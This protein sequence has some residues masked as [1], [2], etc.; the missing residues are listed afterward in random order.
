MN[1]NR[2]FSSPNHSQR[3]GN[4]E[5]V[6]IHFTEINFEDTLVRLCDPQAKVSAHYVIKADGEIFNLIDDSRA[7]WHAG[8]SFWGNRNKLNDYSVGIE[9]DNDGKSDFQQEQID[10]CIYLCQH[11]KTIYNIKKQ[12]FI[13]HSDVAPS[14]KIDPGILF[15]WSSLSKFG[16]GLWYNEAAIELNQSQILLKTEAAS[17]EVSNLQK[18]LSK[19]GYKIEFTGIFDVQ[20]SYVV[21]AF[22]AHFNPRLLQKLGIDFYWSDDSKYFWD[23]S[24][25]L[26]LKDLTLELQNPEID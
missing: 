3:Q 26:I 21:R 12:N 19:L 17:D 16:L 20:T 23:E 15:D 25:E 18:N 9:L 1:I 2:K 5:L 11:L 13:G 4:I 8:E 10:S 14:R 24:S 22:Q 7:A 6:I